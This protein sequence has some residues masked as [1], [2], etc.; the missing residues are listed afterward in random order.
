MLLFGWA[1]T[2]VV[3]IFLVKINFICANYHCKLILHP[4]RRRFRVG[5]IE[6]FYL[7]NIILKSTAIAIMECWKVW[8]RPVQRIRISTTFAI[9]IVS[10]SRKIDI[11]LLTHSAEKKPSICTI[12]SI[13]CTKIHTFLLRWKFPHPYDE[14]CAW[15]VKFMICDT[16]EKLEN[17]LAQ[18]FM[19]DFAVIVQL[20]EIVQQRERGKIIIFSKFY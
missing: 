19:Q 15:R 9:G 17:S 12:F 13:P 8:T 5:K 3:V 1:H 14:S 10:H 16:C 6:L 20:L 2:V 11:I 7:N 4:S 18:C